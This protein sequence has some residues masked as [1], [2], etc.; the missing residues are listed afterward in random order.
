MRKVSDISQTWQHGEPLSTELAEKFLEKTIP[1]TWL[2]RFSDDKNDYVL[3]KKTD[4][5]YSHEILPE[6]DT[7]INSAIAGFSKILPFESMLLLNDQFTKSFYYLGELDEKTLSLLLDSNG[8]GTWLIARKAGEQ[9]NSLYIVS[10]ECDVRK[11]PIPE[12]IT[13]LLDMETQLKS[14]DPTINICLDNYIVFI[15]PFSSVPGHLKLMLRLMIEDLFN[16]KMKEENISKQAFDK[17]EY[18]KL[19]KRE[20]K[21]LPN[22]Y[23][24]QKDE[25]AKNDFRET[26][27]KIYQV[28][29]KLGSGTYKIAKQMQEITTSETHVRGKFKNLTPKQIAR[30]FPQMETILKLTRGMPYI[31]AGHYVVFKS[32]KTSQ[33][34]AAVM[35]EYAITDLFKAIQKGLSD[36][37]KK[38]YSL[39]LLTGLEALHGKKIAHRDIKPHNI[40][41][42]EDPKT[43]ETTA[44]H[45]DFDFA[46]LV[47]TNDGKGSPAYIPPEILRNPDQTL[48]CLLAGD[49]FAQGMVL[50]EIWHGKHLWYKHGQPDG[51]QMA[52]FYQFKQITTED[53][54]NQFF[55]EPAKDTLD[56]LLW[57]MMHVQPGKRPSAAACKLRYMQLVNV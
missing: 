29:S 27:I 51:P 50:Y 47:G 40:N 42:V 11:F 24:I 15:R 26:Q 18:F 33:E 37:N 54:Y 22:S 1:G 39:H 32:A 13:S 46:T 12:N 57:E 9:H 48:E 52:T 28:G 17:G 23:I 3:S 56:H 43:G 49:V 53:E 4:S 41:I 10:D 19:S 38:K 6:L 20:Y 45:V 35:S 14:A 55:P 25:E 21:V 8:S 5:G 30:A 44:N 34:Y 16:R 31:K 2:I 7:S 36:D